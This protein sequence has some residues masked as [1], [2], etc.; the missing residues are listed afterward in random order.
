[1][2][3]PAITYELVGRDEATGARAGLLHTPHGSYQTPSFMPVR[4]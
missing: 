4:T 2:T 3:K 1:M